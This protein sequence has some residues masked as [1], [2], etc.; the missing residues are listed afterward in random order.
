VGA[1]YAAFLAG[2]LSYFYGFRP[3]FMEVSSALW[4]T[5]MGLVFLGLLA[6]VLLSPGKIQGLRAAFPL[7]CGLMALLIVVALS[8]QSL[9]HWLYRVTGQPPSQGDRLFLR[10]VLGILIAWLARQAVQVRRKLKTLEKQEGSK[11]TQP[12][13]RR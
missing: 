10:I 7:I 6:Q 13:V 2:F 4:A 3:G 9:L 12:Q 5:L 11:S 8:P 1:I